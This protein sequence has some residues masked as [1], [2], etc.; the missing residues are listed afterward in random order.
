[1]TTKLNQIFANLKA[2][3]MDVKKTEGDANKIDSFN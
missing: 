3:I 2:V 1:M